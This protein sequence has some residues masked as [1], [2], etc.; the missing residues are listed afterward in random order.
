MHANNRPTTQ[1]RPWRQLLWTAL[2]GVVF[3]LL[4][5]GEIGEDVLRSGRNSLHWH[6]ASGDI[7]VVK[8]DN[9]SL[10]H[11][12]RWPWARRHHA[13]IVD[14]LTRGGAQRIFIDV[15]FVGARDGIEGKTE[16]L[17]HAT[18]RSVR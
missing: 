1:G 17:R 14:S 2:A 9:S 3:G 18:P 7:V 15:Q 8:I 11:A 10:K 6:K 12:G 16:R 13:E 5:L 4:G